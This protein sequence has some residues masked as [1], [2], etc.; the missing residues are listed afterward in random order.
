M[1]K[2]ED[3]FFAGKYEDIY[4]ITLEALEITVS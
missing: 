3:I 1:M 4:P 2:C